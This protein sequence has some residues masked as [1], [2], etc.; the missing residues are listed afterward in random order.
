M[1]LQGKSAVIYG[2]SGAIGSAVARAFAREGARVF[3]AA[4]TQAKLDAVVREIGAAGGLAEAAQVD[5]FDPEAVEAHAQAVAAKAGGIDIALDAVS[6]MEDQSTPISG[7]SLE[8]FMDPIERSL[9]TLFN[10]SKAVAPHMGKRRPGVILTLTLPLTRVRIG[11]PAANWFPPQSESGR[12]LAALRA[13]GVSGVLQPVR[14]VIQLPEGESALSARRLSGLKALSDSLRRDPR[15]REVRGVATVQPGMS[16]LQLALFYDDPAA[17]R[18]RAPAFFDAYLSADTRT[19]LVDAVPAD[20][21][22]LTGT[23]SPSGQCRPKGSGGAGVGGEE[24]LDGQFGQRDVDGGP[25]GGH[26]GEEGEVAGNQE[27]HVA[28]G[29]Q[30]VDSG[31]QLGEVEVEGDEDRL[32]DEVGGEGLFEGGRGKNGVRSRQQLR[33]PE[34]EQVRIP[35]PGADEVHL[36]HARAFRFAA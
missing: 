26:R 10:T 4:R 1:L 2:G 29:T 17:A 11:L 25:E 30:G 18:R 14:I 28:G 9:R 5:A 31:E 3:L 36:A 6:V 20:T 32:A 16:R 15:V 19:T 35:R 13:M 23:T 21:V 27:R 24:R 8:A 7:R 34:G 33:P 22:S 12:G